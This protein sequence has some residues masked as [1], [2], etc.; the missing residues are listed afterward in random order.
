MRLI[1]FSAYF[2]VTVLF[3]CSIGCTDIENSSA[4]KNP[5]LFRKVSAEF[6]GL[7][8]ENRIIESDTL[9]Y[10]DYPYIY[11]GAGVALGDFNNDSLLDIFITGN[12]V[13]NKLYINQGNLQFKDVSQAAGV[14][15]RLDK[16]YTGVTV[17]DINND[18]YL[19]LY[20]SVSGKDSD[21]SNELYVNNGNLTFTESSVQ[22][23]INDNGHSI[24]SVFFDYD[25]DGYLDLFVA[26]YPPIPLSLSPSSY[27]MLMD[28]N[29][30]RFSGKLY[31]NT[32]NGS[33]KDYTD[34]AGVRN[35]GLTLGVVAADVNGDGWTDLYLSND[36]G[37]PDYYYQN[38]QDGTFKEFLKESF[39]HTSMFGMG[40]DIAD[41]NNDGHM[42]IVQA[43]MAPE[44]YSR[45]KVNMASMSRK[46]FWSSVNLGL[47]YQYMQNSLQ[48]N[49]GNM[50]ESGIPRFS[51]I[52]NF[53]G[54]AKTDWSW[55]CL[56]ADLDNDGWKDLIIT[57][58]M[59]R[60]VNDNDLNQRTLAKDFKTAFGP[61]DMK[62]YPSVP[63]SNYVFK[64]NSDLS[65]KN[66]TE[67]WELDDKGFSNGIAYGD[68]DN[69]GDLDIVVN[70]LDDKITLYQNNG[71]SGRHYLR[72]KLNGP[73]GN[74]LGIGARLTLKDPKNGSSQYQ[75]LTLTR[76][77][78]SSVEPIVHFGLG[79]NTVPR[80]LQI[81][82]PNGNMQQQWIRNFDRLIEISYQDST[83]NPDNRG[84]ELN[85]PFRISEE[86]MGI[87]YQHQEDSTDDF[88]YEPLL[89]HKYSTVGPGLAVG[90]VND[91]GLEDFF[92]GNATNKSGKLFYQASDGGFKELPGPWINHREREDT[93]AHFF[94]ADGDG[95]HDL[96]VVS[97]GY[98]LNDPRIYQDR[99]YINSDG[100]FIDSKSLPKMPV[101][102]KSIAVCDFDR[103]GDIDLFV[104]GR[105]I[106][107]SYPATPK[108]YLLVN[109]GGIDEDLKFEPSEHSDGSWDNIGMVTSAQW[110]DL[111]N[112]GWQ[113]LVL[114]GEWMP[115][116][117]FLNNSGTLVDST[118]AWGTADKIGWWYS[119]HPMDVDN[120]GDIDLVAGNLG[121]NYKYTA[122]T[123]SPF[124]VYMNDFDQNGTNDI[125]LGYY[126]NDKLVPL[127]GRECSSEQVPAIAEKFA[128]FREFASADL[129]DIYGE[130]MLDR[131][132]TFSATTFAH[133]WLENIEGQSFKWHQLPNRCQISTITDITD[134]DYDGDQFKD[135]LVVGGLYDSEVE[136]P[137]SD[138]GVGLVLRNKKGKGFEALPAHQT[139]LY[140]VGD[141]REVR[142]ISIQNDKKFLF[143]KNDGEPIWYDFDPNS[144]PLVNIK[145]NYK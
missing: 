51:D 118:K 72:V 98:D 109:N 30:L 61:L 44:D 116:K 16:W 14:E 138:A 5:P 71:Y 32:G 90:D 52:A 67:E 35:F 6:S 89:P 108:S 113:D 105:V 144:A 131:S 59:K 39:P 13:V 42:D 142:A 86:P 79:E 43:D 8:F 38:M 55:S 132:I 69:D 81:R 60:D 28:Q 62:N 7:S 34:Q 136:T 126:K 141:I 25:H 50:G 53:A 37:V 1:L 129:Y 104:G 97:G 9:S 112:D 70:N 122:S 88:L 63:L 45:S 127:R 140:A 84:T 114:A 92:V 27:R 107:G 36:F 20:L 73:E 41:I 145:T 66:T 3:L 17:T 123:E 130:I 100:A 139:G 85:R 125:V 65:F 68:L 110:V 121:L 78:Q 48:L 137:R 11:L 31:T 80:L 74:P 82:W 12:M 103:D 57:N 111:N 94:D 10:Y 33:F 29:E 40:I 56:L 76:G 18:G 49:N 106:P 77:Y 75:E 24:Q 46:T 95:D 26:N 133:Y 23:G 93:G 54:I 15:G 91:D 143:T 22:Y 87:D 135:L 19:D 96:Y 117:V 99:L 134:F 102:G 115:V 101:S 64:N 83:A 2:F 58:G 120:D 128:T 4:Q 119:L 124:K 21:R 47:H